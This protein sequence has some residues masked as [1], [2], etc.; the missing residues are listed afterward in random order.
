MNWFNKNL[1]KIILVGVIV[2]TYAALT[3]L[4][5]LNSSVRDTEVA[6]Q[7]MSPAF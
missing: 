5:F 4:Y 6:L 1:K 3:N 2:S 7:N